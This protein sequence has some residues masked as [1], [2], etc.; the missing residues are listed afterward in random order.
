M[1]ELAARQHGVV[2][3]AQLVALGMGRRHIDQLLSRGRLHPL[4]RGVYAVGHRLLTRESRW[5]AAVFAAGEGAMLSHR[6]AAELWGLWRPRDGAI[7]LTRNR[8]IRRQAEIVA[9]RREVPSDER[10]VVDGI[11][12]TSPFRTA[13][14]LAAVLDERALERAW[15]EVKVRGLTDRLS[16]WDLLRRYPRRRGT[17]AWRRL[18]ESEAPEGVTR[19]ELEEAFLAFLD[20][21]G[22]PRPRLNAALSLRGGFVEVDCLWEEQRLA[23]ELDGR[24][25]HGTARSFESDRR[26][27]RLLLAEGWRTM[28]ITWRQLREEPASLAADLLKALHT[29]GP[30]PHPHAR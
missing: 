20:A 15:N 16:P 1:A 7:E 4:H 27:D 17:A 22:L 30:S 18:L 3:R 26:R 2:A 14:D 6:S 9:H 21:C 8:K 24:R 29:P 23:V 11:P 28:R 10:G 5:V 19:S 13:F 25:F 12:V